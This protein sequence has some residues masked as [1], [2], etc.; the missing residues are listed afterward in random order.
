MR[1]A[2][3]PPFKY[4]PSSAAPSFATPPSSPP[5]S[6]GSARSSPSSYD[7]Y[8]Q[9]TPKPLLLSEFGIDSFDNA[10]GAADE[11]VQASH[12]SGQ[13]EAL[14]SPAATGCATVG[15]VVFEWMDEPWKGE[16]HSRPISPDLASAA[17]ISARKSTLI[18][19]DLP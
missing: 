11:P 10:A 2:Q 9:A 13:W 16:V 14:I 12:L 3:T 15:G 18:S 7:R 19:H 8:E 5:S 6:L 1:S 4:H 17:R